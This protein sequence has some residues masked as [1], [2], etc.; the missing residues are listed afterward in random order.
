MVSSTVDR[1]TVKGKLLEAEH[2]RIV[3]T[4]KKKTYELIRTVDISAV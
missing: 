2:A 1:N 3:A 4:N